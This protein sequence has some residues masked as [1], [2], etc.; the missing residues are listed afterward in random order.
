MSERETVINW[1]RGEENCSYYTSIKKEIRK[2]DA[3]CNKYPDECTCVGKDK[4]SAT[5][6]YPAKWNVIRR[7]RVISEEERQRRSEAFK[8]RREQM[9][10]RKADAQ[11]KK[12]K[13]K[14]ETKSDK[15]AKTKKSAKDKQATKEPASTE[16][17]KKAKK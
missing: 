13:Q 16:K 2:M 5:Y 9:M 7:P 6:R 1:S 17:P 8:E 12:E 4:D 15:P 10:E 11:C 14:S 3:L